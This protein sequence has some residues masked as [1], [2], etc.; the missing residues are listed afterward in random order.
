[1]DAPGPTARPFALFRVPQDVFPHIRTAMSCQVSSPRGMCCLLCL[2]I[3]SCTA[4]ASARCS[5]LLSPVVH[6]TR[7]SKP[8]SS[9]VSSRTSNTLQQDV[10][11]S[12]PTCFSKTSSSPLQ[13]ASAR[14]P[15][16]P[17]N[18]LQQDFLFS[19]PTCFSKM[20]SSPI[21]T[22]TSNTHLLHPASL[23]D[24]TFQ[25]QHFRNNFKAGCAV[26]S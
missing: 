3:S 11:F 16:L 1:M 15:L 9:P 6:P 19:D 20:S 25:N 26:T 18:M 8:S 14:R 10:L 21:S 5:I 17:S 12:H 7:F 2:L 4:L 23:L 24:P 13:H 22:R